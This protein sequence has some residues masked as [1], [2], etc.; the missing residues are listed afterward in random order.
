MFKRISIVI[1]ILLAQ[2]LSAQTPGALQNITI[3]H[4]TSLVRLGGAGT[5]G[6][7]PG[8]AVVHQ[9]VANTSIT[10]LQIYDNVLPGGLVRDQKGVC[11]NGTDATSVLSCVTSL[12]GT[13]TA[14]YCFDHNGL[15]TTTATS[16]TVTG[17]TNNPPYPTTSPNCPFP[18]TGNLL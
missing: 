14:N 12:N 11:T 17:T 4:V 16:G 13:G 6:F 7:G 3:H 9:M 15:A 2:S 10:N 18:T 5:I 8:L 1:A